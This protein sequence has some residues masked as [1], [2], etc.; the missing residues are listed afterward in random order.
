MGD[1]RKYVLD[2]LTAFLADQARER[3]ARLRGD[4]EADSE[5]VLLQRHAALR[6]P[7][8][9]EQYEEARQRGL[10]AEGEGESVGYWLGEAY[11]AEGRARARARQAGALAS[12]VPHDSDHFEPR[13]LLERMAR[14]AHTARRRAI[15]RS[16]EAFAPSLLAA[17]REGLADLEESASSGLFIDAPPPVDRANVEDCDTILTDTADAWL[18]LKERMEHASS[19]PI[20][21]WPDLVFAL[22]AQRFDPLAPARRRFARLAERFLELG[23]RDVL[24]KRVRVHES[25]SLRRARIVALSIPLDVRIVA[26]STDGLFSDRDAL[27][28]LGRA[29]SLAMTHPA[30]SPLAARPTAGTVGRALGALMAHLLTDARFTALDSSVA[31]GARELALAL[32]LVELRVRAA[33]VI[34]QRAIERSDYADAARDALLDALRVDIHP[35]IAACLCMP[36]EPEPLAPLRALRHAVPIFCAMRERYDEDFFRNP[37]TL[38]VWRA[39][40]ERGPSLSVETWVKELGAEP[41]SLRTR[42]RE[43]LA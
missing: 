42:L 24:V 18:E 6:H 10:F 5:T 28:V 43:L 17:Q 12:R 38:E 41:S 32:E 8:M 7:R 36:H 2:A 25:R 39:A 13:D 27:V 31:R 23:L 22:R 35:T 33:A 37:R 19:S 15:A 30:L 3:L 29:A 26:S 4:V 40:C 11:A 34:A 1:P 14:E 16:L 21:D 9:R 20:E